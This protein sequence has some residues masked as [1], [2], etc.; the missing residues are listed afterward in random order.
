MFYKV[1]ILD[2]RGA[3]ND[4]FDAQLQPAIDRRAVADAATQLHRQGNGLQNSLDCRRVD[5]LTR[6]SAVEVDQMQP[7]EALGLEVARLRGGV[8]VEDRGLVHL[9]AQQPHSLAVL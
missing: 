9:T 4:A 5:W 8:L 1:R 7:F 2:G 6:K 3:Q